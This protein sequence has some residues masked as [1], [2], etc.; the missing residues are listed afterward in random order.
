MQS[1]FNFADIKVT[2]KSFIGRKPSMKGIFSVDLF[3]NLA[4]SNSSMTKPAI[5]CVGKTDIG[6][7]R[8]TNEDA[9]CTALEM[10][11]CLVADGL[12]GAAAGELASRIFSDAASEAFR[13]AFDGVEVE[14]TRRVKA[15][16]R[17]ANERIQNHVQQHPADMG[18]GCTAELF[19]FQ[20]KDL[21]S[22]MLGTVAPTD[23]AKGN[24]NSSQRTILSC[25]VRSTRDF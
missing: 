20:M 15:A 6:L 19:A 13:G 14:V 23:F 25:K 10:G 7:K 9:Y 1:F 3:S 5:K 24:L 11:F 8:T 17:L 18:M 22:G 12:G 4:K 16:F 2:V 21:W